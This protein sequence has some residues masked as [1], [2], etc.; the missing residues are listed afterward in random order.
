ME[1]GTHPSAFVMKA[2][3]IRMTSLYTDC[4]SRVSLPGFSSRSD[5]LN[6][7]QQDI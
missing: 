4:M 7:C 3:R 1:T 6:H 5:S 2:G